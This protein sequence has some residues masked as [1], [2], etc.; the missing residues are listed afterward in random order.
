MREGEAQKHASSASHAA[1]AHTKGG[2]AALR[3]INAD[4]PLVR[5]GVRHRVANEGLRAR[6]KQEARTQ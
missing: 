4:V 1:S 3:E 6:I 2:V 5:A